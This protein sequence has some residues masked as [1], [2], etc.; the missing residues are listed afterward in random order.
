MGQAQSGNTVGGADGPSRHV[1]VPADLL[2]PTNIVIDDNELLQAVQRRIGRGALAP[3]LCAPSCKSHILQSCTAKGPA[4]AEP[5]Q[6]NN[7]SRVYAFW[8][9]LRRVCEMVNVV[10]GI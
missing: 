6:M 2:I 1:K 3:F 4:S 9:A 7:I 10:F 8:S 5:V